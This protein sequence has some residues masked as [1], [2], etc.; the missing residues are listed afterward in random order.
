MLLHVQSTQTLRLDNLCFFFN[1]LFFTICA[2]FLLKIEEDFNILTF[3]NWE[4][5]VV[6]YYEA[7][8]TLDLVS[9][10]TSA[11][12]GPKMG[13]FPSCKNFLLE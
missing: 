7:G 2:P 3:N 5:N 4:K 9:W 6:Y 12:N 8:Q 13:I 11:G 1:I 10:E